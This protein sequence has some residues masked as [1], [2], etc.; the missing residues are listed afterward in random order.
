MPLRILS[1][2]DSEQ[3]RKLDCTFCDLFTAIVVPVLFRRQ[4]N[5]FVKRL[6]FYSQREKSL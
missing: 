5:F 2:I 6:R 3:G 4:N 1:R